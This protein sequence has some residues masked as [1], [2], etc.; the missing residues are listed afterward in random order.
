MQH[1]HDGID[2]VAAMHMMKLRFRNAYNAR[3]KE[4][5]K[6][7]NAIR[8]IK[9]GKGRQV[10][11]VTKKVGPKPRLDHRNYG[12]WY[13]APTQWE[14]RFVRKSTKAARENC[15]HKHEPRQPDKGTKGKKSP[16]IKGKI[17]HKKAVENEPNANKLT[18]EKPEEPEVKSQAEIDEE[19]SQVSLRIIEVLK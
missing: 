13:L 9:Y 19:I 16:S 10:T 18:V 8:G 6:R 7:R 4:R 17:A 2:T 1:H 12:A 14:T 5:E 3:I 15:I 11:P